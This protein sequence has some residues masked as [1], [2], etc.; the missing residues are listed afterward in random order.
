MDWKVSCRQRGTR[1]KPRVE[2]SPQIRQEVLHG[3]GTTYQSTIQQFTDP[4]SLAPYCLRRV[5]DATPNPTG[6]GG[7]DRDP[8]RILLA[9]YPLPGWDRSEE[10][11]VGKECRYRWSAE[12]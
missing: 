8:W 7:A 4:V 3:M 12:D 5:W 10:R 1:L 2:I 6:E 11:R 9:Q